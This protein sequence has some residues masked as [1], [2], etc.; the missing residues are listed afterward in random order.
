MGIHL[1]NSSED[2]IWA[3]SFFCCCYKPECC[4]QSGVGLSIDTL[5]H[6][7]CAPSYRAANLVV[8]VQHY[9]KIMNCF[10]K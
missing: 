2:D 3:I 9:K 10:P 1:F 6:S 4:E 5:C 8:D 7:L